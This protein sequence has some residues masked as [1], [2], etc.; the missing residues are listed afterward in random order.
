M[1]QSK[2][3]D[4]RLFSVQFDRT[5]SDWNVQ[6]SPLDSDTATIDQNKDQIKF[7]L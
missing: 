7:I 4:I 2:F 6:F 5:V 3:I 1:V